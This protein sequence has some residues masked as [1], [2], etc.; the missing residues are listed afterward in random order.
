MRRGGRRPAP[1]ALMYFECLFSIQSVTFARLCPTFLPVGVS[2]QKMLWRASC[3]ALAI[4]R[5]CMSTP[6]AFAIAASR[7][8]RPSA[9]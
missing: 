2:Q 1:L 5:A 4:P 3:L 7:F 9:D 6:H 8:A